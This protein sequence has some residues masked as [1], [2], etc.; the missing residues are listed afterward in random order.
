[1]TWDLCV[2]EAETLLTSTRIPSSLEIITLIKRINP[3]R[4]QLPEPDRERGYRIN[5]ALQNLL[6]EHYGAAF[7]LVPFAW[8]PEI[9]L[10]KHTAL[11]SVDACHALVG[12]L[13]EK[14]LMSVADPAEGAASKP[15]PKKKTKPP[16]SRSPTDA[17]R[18][19]QQML[20][21]YEYCRAEELLSGIRLENNGALPSL[22][23]A[24]T[25]LMEEI[26]AYGTAVELLLSQPKCVLKDNSIKETLAQA[27]YRNGMIPEARALFDV[28]PVAGMQKLSLC[29]YADIS[30]KDGSL[31]HAYGLLE[32]AEEKEGFAAN[33][34]RL[35][36]EIRE[37]MHA[38]AQ[39]WLQKAQE[40]L[41][42]DDVAQAESMGLQALSRFPALQ[43]AREIVAEVRTRREAE[44]LTSLWDKL[45]KS[46]RGQS[47][48]DLLET[49]LERDREHQEKIKTLLVTEK[50][51]VK[52]EW[53]FS[54]LQ[55]LREETVRKRWEK[56]YAIID[57][58]SHQN[59]HVDSYREACALSPHFSVLY[60][61]RR[62]RKVTPKTAKEAWL[63][64]IQARTALQSGQREGCLELMDGVKEYF[65]HCPDFAE[66]YRKLLGAEQESSR[67]EIADLL[68]QVAG[69]DV[70]EV[71]IGTAFN[72][73]RKKMTVL[74]EKERVEYK[75][76]MQDRLAQLVTEPDDEEVGNA[77]HCALLLG[78]AEDA[79]QLRKMIRDADRLEQIEKEVSE[80]MQMEVSP[81]TLAFSD[82]MPVDLT[83]KPALRCLGATYRHILLGDEEGDLIMVDLHDMTATKF[84]C[85]LGRL[86]LADALPAQGI[87]LFR[88]QGE[89]FFARAELSSG[90][91]AV[92]AVFEGSTGFL[93]PS[94]SVINDIYLSSDRATDYYLNIAQ[95]DGTAPA[96]M[97]RLRLR[98]RNG[99]ADTVRIN[100]EPRLYSW[101]LSSNPEKFIIGTTDQTRICAR[102]LTLDIAM[103]FTPE[104]WEVDEV[105]GH[106]YYYFGTTLRKAD[107]HLDDCDEFPHSDAF[108][109]FYGYHRMLGLCPATST[110]HLALRER[111][112]LYDYSANK[113]STVF[114]ADAI[115]STRPAKNWYCYHYDKDAGEL[116]LRDVTE[117]VFK[118]LD[119]RTVPIKNGQKWSNE[120]YREAYE[121]MYFGYKDTP[122]P[123][124]FPH[125]EQEPSE[126]TGT[127]Q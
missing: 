2:A 36:N 62:L 1:M 3:T 111:A 39:T 44:E 89:N 59:D 81:L 113:L 125:A 4:L 50:A 121:M 19:A 104:I 15:C 82:D 71:R 31:T 107:F 10:I 52:E 127:V 114:P 117:E 67:R 11:P 16:S 123:L 118:I 106:I 25:M 77:Y 22:L 13:S 87:F 66:E 56:C 92:K 124:V 91:G 88:I 12:A 58:L 43:Q 85:I 60:N 14:A 61:N 75:K 79:A 9:V 76:I 37:A 7:W 63:R 32:R 49:L 35:K 5:G 40:A 95:E 41:R 68:R 97:G 46:E 65:E 74:P 109:F 120:Q 17:V 80:P 55:R 30:F 26:G 28:L 96:V 90:K 21:R 84:A 94:D 83:S 112:A 93:L 70:D 54:Q 38:E 18:G 53:C 45:E 27:Y 24:A 86:Y 69:D 34:D 102:N 64:L 33:L 78:K 103:G 99:M 110:A 126:A 98:S 51:T 100:N 23:R 29:A 105:N 119:W 20:E 115:I 72:R 57:S 47:R 8:N 73:I 48:L 101:R 116:K 6:L 122:E 108:M 42:R